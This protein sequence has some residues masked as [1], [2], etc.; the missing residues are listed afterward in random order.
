MKFLLSAING[1]G[2]GHVARLLAVARELR[3]R[4][5]EAE[6]LFL[7]SSEASSVIWQEGF[8]SVKIPS[9]VS[10]REKLIDV[11]DWKHLNMSLAATVVSSFRPDVLIADSFPSGESGELMPALSIIDKKILVLDYLPQFLKKGG[12]CGT[13]CA[14]QFGSHSLRAWRGRTECCAR[15]SGEMGGPGHFSRQ[16]GIAE[17]GSSVAAPP[18]ERGS[19]MFSRFSGRRRRN[20]VRQSHGMALPNSRK[21]SRNSIRG[22]GPAVDTEI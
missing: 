22:S 8:A 9:W 7:T 11:D 21:I 1:V 16:R 20:W 13:N 3:R 14:L 2:L 15:G 17:P 5:P 10:T 12:L 18:F 4:V 6:F 19:I